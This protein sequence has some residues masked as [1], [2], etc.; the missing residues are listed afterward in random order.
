M[1]KRKR[2]KGAR[3]SKALK[4]LKRCMYKQ[5]RKAHEKHQGHP[6]GDEFLES[7]EHVNEL[8][9]TCY[10]RCTKKRKKRKR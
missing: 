6:A 2:T 3:Q 4:C 10:A 1:G 8:L 9:D 5:D 7:A